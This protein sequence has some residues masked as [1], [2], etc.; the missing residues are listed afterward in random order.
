MSL[1]RPLDSKFW[2]DLYIFPNLAVQF[3]LMS[4]SQE[5]LGTIHL[6]H[7][8]VKK[9]SWWTMAYIA[10]QNDLA[11]RSRINKCLLF[12]ESG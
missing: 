8:N 5:S 1:F 2:W 4:D 12:D 9:K 3:H 6:E 7:G 11:Q 10:C